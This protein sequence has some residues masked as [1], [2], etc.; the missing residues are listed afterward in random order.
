MHD[1]DSCNICHACALQAANELSMPSSAAAS[2]VSNRDGGGAH[3]S[4]ELPSFHDWGQPGNL[5][6][7]SVKSAAVPSPTITSHPQSQAADSAP[8][9]P[10]Q[11]PV[12]PQQQLPEAAQAL[13]DVVSQQEGVPDELMA[14]QSEAAQHAAVAL[15]SQQNFDNRQQGMPTLH[16][17]LRMSAPDP[18]VTTCMWMLSSLFTVF[19]CCIVTCCRDSVSGSCDITNYGV[20]SC[21]TL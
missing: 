10:A 2:P 19:F 8:Q 4:Q 9:L 12:Q 7:A 15:Y 5:P 21:F 16:A 6:S 17:C 3:M 1:D 11:L 14:L 18:R 20:Y 13:S